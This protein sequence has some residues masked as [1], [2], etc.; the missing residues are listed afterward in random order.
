MYTFN[1]Y[2]DSIAVTTKKSIKYSHKHFSN[3]LT[4]ES[5]SAISLQ[6]TVKEIANNISSVNFNKASGTNNIPYIILFHLKNKFRGNWQIYSNSFSWLVFFLQ[7]SNLQKLFLF[8]RKIRNLII[9]TIA[10]SPCYQTLKKYLKSLCI[11]DC[12]PFSIRIM[13]SIT[14]SLDSENSIQ[15][16][17]P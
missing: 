2:L 7:R 6:P 15:H 13:L 11:R 1:N 9:A 14:Y 12:I 4:K 8:L 3:Y 10:Q 16:L 17:M 5:G